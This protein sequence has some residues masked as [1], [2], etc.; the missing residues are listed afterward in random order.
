M[1]GKKLREYLGK[2]SSE[3]SI[4]NFD[5]LPIFNEIQHYFSI[6]I[7]KKDIYKVTETIYRYLK[8]DYKDSNKIWQDFS[9]INEWR[10]IGVDDS[11]IIKSL[12]ERFSKS[13]GDLKF[14]NGIATQRNKIYSFDISTE[15]DSYFYFNNNNNRVKIERGIT[16]PFILPNKQ[17]KSQNLR[18]IFPYKFDNKSQKFV[19]ISE[20]EFIEKYPFT[21]NY[22]NEYKSELVNRKHD[23][24]MP[25]WFSYGRS[26]GINQY[27]KRLYLP[28][29]AN[30]VYTSIS[31]FDNE[32]FAAGY[33]IFD[34]S[35]DYLIK[36]SRIIESNIFSYY[37][38]K[39]S[40]PYSNN[41]YSTAKNMIKNFSIPSKEDL[42]NVKADDMTE[43]FIGNL[44]GLTQ[45]Q[46]SEIERNLFYK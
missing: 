6:T 16:R 18:I 11:N 23:K 5:G 12:E 26:Q 14:Q 22:L 7:F 38:K 28:Y 2:N 15:D 3:I 29:M 8:T 31:K 33:A 41:Y 32:V 40:K 45:N 21:Y 25:N 37:L 1:N 43:N 42:Q 46:I 35:E 20:R 34:E 36:L 24:S 13:I 30:K 10:T 39:V 17:I 27:G 44:Y 19:S 4:I 9:G